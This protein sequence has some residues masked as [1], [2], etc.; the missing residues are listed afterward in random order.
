VERR[1]KL[2]CAKGEAKAIGNQGSL[3]FSTL[4]TNSRLG[5]LY[6]VYANK[7]LSAMI[8]SYWRLN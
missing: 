3:F 7:L 4:I 2:G 5:E 8:L 1:A 6:F